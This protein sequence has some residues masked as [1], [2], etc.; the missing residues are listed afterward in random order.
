MVD[1]VDGR[2]AV[3]GR[4]PSTC[5]GVACRRRCIYHA[6]TTP[7]AVL[8][9]DAASIILGRRR[10]RGRHWTLATAPRVRHS[11]CKMPFSADAAGLA[12]PTIADGSRVGAPL[13]KRGCAGVQSQVCEHAAHQ[14]QPAPA[15]VMAAHPAASLPS[16]LVVVRGW[17]LVRVLERPHRTSFKLCC[18][19]R[20]VITDVARDWCERSSARTGRPSICD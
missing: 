1:V 16:S 15:P 13:T 2:R 8:R 19:G 9:R 12:Q 3:D 6:S 18:C 7:A 14:A 20:R 5:R 11:G 4:R 10:R 17:G